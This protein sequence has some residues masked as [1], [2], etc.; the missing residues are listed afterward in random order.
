MHTKIQGVTVDNASANSVFMRE[1]E[2][3]LS[4][5]GIDF[6]ADDQHFRC[7]AHILNLAVQDVLKLLNIEMDEETNIFLDAPEMTND[8]CIDKDNEGEGEEEPEEEGGEEDD[9]ESDILNDES[10]KW[11]TLV[12]K[13]R[14]ACKKIRKSEVLMKTLK[15]CC[16]TNHIKFV[17]PCLDVKTRFNSTFKML[18]IVFKLKDALDMMWSLKELKKFQI[19]ENDWFSLSQILRFLRNFDYSTTFLSSEKKVTLPSVIVTVN[20]LLDNIETIVFELEKNR[21]SEADDI[22]LLSFQAA[23]DKI[24][25]HYKKTNWLYCVSLILDPR[26][27][28]KSFD[29]TVWGKELKNMAYKKFVKILKSEYCQDNLDMSEENEGVSE[30]VEKD[31]F[32]ID[33][34]SVYVK[35]KEVFKSWETEVERYLESER[36]DEDTDVLQWWKQNEAKYP[37]IAKMARDVLSIMATSVPVERLFSS[38]S[39]TMTKTRNCLSDLSMKALICIHSWMKSTL[40]KLICNVSL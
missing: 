14:S 36:A 26:H 33:F 19:S 9:S 25:K 3:L 18:S 38:A 7:I 37:R 15:S 32:V 4:S 8:E 40:K 11:K 30:N 24:L 16:E 28:M 23:R 21:K 27:K 20:L 2:L 35:R 10:D 13:I 5:E 34:R 22:L 1:L 6:D 31:K 39:L 29:G 12:Y 17:K